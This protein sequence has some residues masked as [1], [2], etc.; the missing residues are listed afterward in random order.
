MYAVECPS[1][2]SSSELSGDVL[3]AF[4]IL[5]AISGLKEE[6]PFKNSDNAFLDTP[7]SAAA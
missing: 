2:S 7:R 1:V 6:C 5:I 4:P 3:V